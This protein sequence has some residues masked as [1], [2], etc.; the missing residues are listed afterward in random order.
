MMTPSNL[1]T[2]FNFIVQNRRRVKTNNEIELANR[3]LRTFDG[4]WIRLFSARRSH[5]TRNNSY[6]SPCHHSHR[7]TADNYYSNGTQ[8]HSRHASLQTP[9]MLIQNT[10]SISTTD[11][12][13]TRL[14]IYSSIPTTKFWILY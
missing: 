14:T 1:P 12:Y 7:A 13:G 3:R 11:A 9:H 4:F 8:A 2:A 10:G 5:L 6:Y